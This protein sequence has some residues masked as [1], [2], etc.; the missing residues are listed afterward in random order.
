M[1]ICLVELIYHWL[2]QLC[3]INIVRNL[4][5]QNLLLNM[6]QCE[7]VFDTSANLSK[8]QQGNTRLLFSTNCV[9]YIMLLKIFGVFLCLFAFQTHSLM[10]RRSYG[11]QR[12]EPTRAP[13]WKEAPRVP[14]SSTKLLF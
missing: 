13:G 4:Y 3:G 9:L 2:H 8:F 1:C 7:N 10:Q 6:L 14:A 12:G 5:Y 11:G